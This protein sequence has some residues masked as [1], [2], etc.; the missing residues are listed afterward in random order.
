MVGCQIKEFQCEQV[1]KTSCPTDLLVG[2]VKQ[3]VPLRPPHGQTEAVEN[4]DSSQEEAEKAQLL[5]ALQP[6]LQ[7]VWEMSV[8]G[9]IVE[10]VR[11]CQLACQVHQGQ[12]SDGNSGQCPVHYLYGD[13]VEV[14]LLVFYIRVDDVSYKRVSKKED[15]EGHGSEDGAPPAR[16]Q[17]Y[18]HVL[19]VPR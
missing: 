18:G 15:G 8:F 4:M 7:P 3:K 17:L 6:A 1:V 19:N 16:K 11:G 5:P 9:T 13:L 12:E 14:T 2:S 10:L